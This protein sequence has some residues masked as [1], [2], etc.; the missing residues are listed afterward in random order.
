MNPYLVYRL[1]ALAIT[2]FVLISVFIIPVTLYALED[3]KEMNEDNPE[4]TSKDPI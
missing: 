3:A 4:P 1:I 2:V